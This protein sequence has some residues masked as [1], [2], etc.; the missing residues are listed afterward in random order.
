[1][2]ALTPSRNQRYYPGI[3]AK[4]GGD[5]L[6]FQDFP[7]TKKSFIRLSIAGSLLLCFE[8][9]A[10]YRSSRAIPKKAAW[11]TLEKKQYCAT[12]DRSIF[13]R[14]D[15][16]GE[17]VYL[18][19]RTR[20]S[21]EVEYFLWDEKENKHTYKRIVGNAV[22]FP[23]YIEM[24]QLFRKDDEVLFKEQSGRVL[25]EFAMRFSHNLSKARSCQ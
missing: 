9:T 12:P 4:P 25:R 18:Q 15:V 5:A 13:F 8:A 2:Q 1:M 24:T 16:R 22:N 3:R 17:N 21:E 23:L 11:V 10:N 7:G 19:V 20:S 14:S 6:F